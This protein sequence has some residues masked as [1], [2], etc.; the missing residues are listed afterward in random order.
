MLIILK[1]GLELQSSDKGGRDTVLHEA[2]QIVLIIFVCEDQLDAS[3]VIQFRDAVRQTVLGVLLEKLFK[4]APDVH[5][6]ARPGV[7]V[8]LYLVELLSWPFAI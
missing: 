7:V 6:H 2:P 8:D 5:R 4:A 3:V 1:T